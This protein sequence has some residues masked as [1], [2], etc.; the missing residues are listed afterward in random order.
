MKHR[1]LFLLLIVTISTLSVCLPANAESIPDYQKVDLDL[2]KMSG[3]IVYSQIYNIMYTPDDYIG[4]IIRLSGYY[5]VFEEPDT[6][7]VYFACIVPDATACC[8][9]GIEFVRADAAQYPQDYPEPGTDIQVTGRL[10]PYTD[11]GID[12][13]HLVDSVLVWDSE[14]D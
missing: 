11:N 4:K 12:Y 9:Q 7:N 6:G 1:I 8:A 2:S 14:R 10:E 5:D 13:L 3:T